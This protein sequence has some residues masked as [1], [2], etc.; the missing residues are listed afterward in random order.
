MSQFPDQIETPGALL[1]PMRSA[2]LPQVVAHLGD[3][4]IAR[5][6]AAIQHPFGIRDAECV[7]ALGR[8]DARRLRV[9]E[10]DGAM[11][12]CL[13][14]VP[15]IWFWLDPAARGRGLMSGALRA[16][17]A[18]QFAHAAPP[19]L[20]TCRGDNAPS[21]A[22]LSQLGFSRMPA[23]RRMFFACEGGAR[24]CH[25]HV[26]T[27][28]QWLMLHPPLLRSGLLNWR[29]ALQKDAAILVQ[30]L[31]ADG[32][33]DRGPWPHPPAL[34]A[35]IETH[36]CRLPGRGLFLA[37]DDDRRVIGM[38]LVDADGGPCATRF[39]TAED[40]ARHGPPTSSPQP[41]AQ[42]HGRLAFPPRC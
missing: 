13:A 17:I 42:G 34:G 14:L 28:E 4:E 10:A 25:D 36:R 30:M 29:P 37:Q 35:F 2:D 9:L 20:A 5:W 31:P 41:P 32:A 40:A 15:E 33:A 23:G 1:R 19:L 24:P 16:A 11:V 27:P 21:L 6:M 3:P 12:G 26:L 38:A 8:D 18:A 7:L 22:L 39:L